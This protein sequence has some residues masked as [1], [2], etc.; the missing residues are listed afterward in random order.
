MIH[1]THAFSHALKWRMTWNKHDLDYQPQVQGCPKFM[2]ARKAASMIQDS[3]VCISSGM[4]G[5]ARCS[6]FYWAVKDSF[7]TNHHP[8]NLTWITVSAQ[9]G[10]GKAPGTIEELDPPGLVTQYISGHVETAK[11]LL[12]SA[13]AGNLDI[14]TL[15]QGEMTFLLEAQANGETSIDSKTGIGTFLDPRIGSGSALT[16]RSGSKYITVS[17]NDPE[18]LTYHLPKIDVAV[19]SAPYADS[20][21][22]IYFH[23]AAVITE[24]IESAMAARKNGG[25]VL[26]A[27]SRVIEE[28]PEKISLSSEYVD[29]IVVNPW[30][31][32][33]A[34][35]KQRKYWPM[36]TRKA[37]ED[38]QRSMDKLR[39][40]NKMLGITPKRGPI[41]DALSRMT[42]SLFVKEVK[43]K[44][45][46][47]LGIGLPEE[48]G[49]FLLKGGI[50]KD[51][52]CS[53]ETGVYNGLPTPGI[54]FGGAINPKE[55]HS[56]AWMFKHYREN[57]DVSVLGLLQVDSEGNVNVSK[58]GPSI[59]DCV[60]P[61]GFINIS[62]CAKTIIFIGSWM[63]QSTFS[64]RDGVLNLKSAGKSRFVNKV[65]E[66]TFSGKQALK[67]G[68]K[69]F[70]VT[71]V[72]IFK[73]THR[74]LELIQVA[75]GIN[76]QKDIVE[77][78]SAR[79]IV[80]RDRTIPVVSNDVMTGKGFHLKYA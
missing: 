39:T 63:A 44:S 76:I 75:P 16:P 2:S 23:D 18:Q 69:V 68:K 4:A 52:I 59:T 80:P 57:L 28:D 26:V 70:Y 78:S 66:I 19:F 61:G 79:I 72:G 40:I 12:K 67:H 42:A 35:I 11:S 6:I 36:F 71:N 56:S 21:G 37:Q 9:G 77:T 20:K 53:S 17:K 32:Q 14:H 65:D 48:V 1:Q 62:C 74:G 33:T 47:N 46:I 64:M 51:V 38:E 73:L 50:Y 54:Y 29:A 55:I 5:N 27:V 60:G 45:L 58:K 34:S 7:L 41:E 30:N 24:N 10:R 15:P 43:K 22:N 13:E 8:K 3:D 25:K 49:R 31:E